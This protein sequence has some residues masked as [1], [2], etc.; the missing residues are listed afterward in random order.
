M[1]PSQGLRFNEQ[2]V[3]VRAPASCA[4]P[5]R[6]EDAVLWRWKNLAPL[7]CAC[8]GVSTP[9]ARVLASEFARHR[10]GGSVVAV[11]GT[12]PNL[13]G[14][15]GVGTAWTERCLGVG[16]INQVTDLINFVPRGFF[17]FFSQRI[18]ENKIFF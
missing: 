11:G 6:T 10:H 8:H 13:G 7:P 17:F 16:A 2:H 9:A 1:A 18:R 3:W 15:A 4:F 5:L 14:N 12:H